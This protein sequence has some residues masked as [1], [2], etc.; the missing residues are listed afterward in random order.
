MLDA[1]VDVPGQD[2]PG[3]L[4]VALQRTLQQALVLLRGLGAAIGEGDHLVSEVL[5]ENQ[6]MA[7]HQDARTAIRDQGLMEFAV[8]SLPMLQLPD[9]RLHQALRRGKLVMRGDHTPLPLDVGILERD[10]HRVAS[11]SSLSSAAP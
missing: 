10:L 1:V 4:G 2:R 9:P 7:F 6:G 8:V 5:V 11:S 3:T